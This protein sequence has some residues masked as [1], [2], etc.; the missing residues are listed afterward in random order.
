MLE[1]LLAKQRTRV[2]ALGKDHVAKEKEKYRRYKY[3]S[4]II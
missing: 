1:I 2:K 4:S 3:A